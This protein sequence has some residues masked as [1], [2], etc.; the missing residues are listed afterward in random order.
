MNNLWK[1][2]IKCLICFTLMVC[3]ASCAALDRLDKLIGGPSEDLQPL[4]EKESSRRVPIPST[5]RDFDRAGLDVP[6]E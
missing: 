2:I 4:A 6:K 1:T 3:L 5:I